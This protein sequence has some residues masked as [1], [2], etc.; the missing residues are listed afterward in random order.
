MQTKIVQP[1]NRKKKKNTVN[2]AIRICVNC[3]NISVHIEN[4]GIYCKE[5][6]MFFEVMEDKKWLK[7]PVG[8]FADIMMLIHH[9]EPQGWISL[10]NSAQPVTLLWFQDTLGV[11]AAMINLGEMINNGLLL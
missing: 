10:K 3:G 2:K 7:L 11:L 1:E 5:C 6:D 4:Y 9:L 8:V